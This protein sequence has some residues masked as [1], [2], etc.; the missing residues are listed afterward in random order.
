MSRI[1]PETE[2][3][4]CGT[5]GCPDPNC[6]Y[7]RD[8]D[9]PPVKKAMWGVLMDERL[10]AGHYIKAF[11]LIEKL[12][13]AVL[14]AGHAQ[15]P[16]VTDEMVERAWAGI[17]GRDVAAICHQASIIRADLKAGLEAALSDTSTDCEGK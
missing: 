6:T 8:D 4:G 10:N 14:A 1:S 17:V 11:D 15:T 7:G 2:T 16:A 9:W 13:A 5:P 3:V 12:H